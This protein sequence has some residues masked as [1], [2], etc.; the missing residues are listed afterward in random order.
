M[1]D[2]FQPEKTETDLRLTLRTT[3]KA[4]K[5]RHSKVAVEKRNSLNLLL[6]FNA[7]LVALFKIGI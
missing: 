3:M 2:F 4:K 7:H 5:K 1:E 6:L